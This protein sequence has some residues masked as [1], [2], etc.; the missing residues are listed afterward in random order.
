MPIGG[1]TFGSDL[2]TLVAM[3]T[4]VN[5]ITSIPVFIALTKGKNPRERRIDRK[6][7]RLNSSHT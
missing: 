6:S 5:P 4:I 1:Y 7:T 3:F 2:T